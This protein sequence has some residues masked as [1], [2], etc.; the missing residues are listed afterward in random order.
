MIHK[1]LGHGRHGLCD[2]TRRGCAGHDLMRE[3]ARGGIV[4][5]ASSQRGLVIKKTARASEA[6]R[7]QQRDE[8]RPALMRYPARVPQ[9][10]EPRWHTL[11]RQVEGITN[12]NEASSAA[13]YPFA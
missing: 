11:R 3:A 7:D 1:R 4:I 5:E 12:T 13:V 2:V 10:R 6:L 8:Y 9:A